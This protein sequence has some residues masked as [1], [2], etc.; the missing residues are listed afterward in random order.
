M[1]N[2]HAFKNQVNML[3]F[4][5]YVE[6]ARALRVG[7]IKVFK[8]GR[9]I[10]ERGKRGDYKKG[11]KPCKSYAMAYQVKLRTSNFYHSC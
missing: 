4:A 9:D 6:I 8:F 2:F 5:E 11:W 3:Y 7:S 10:E 1:Q